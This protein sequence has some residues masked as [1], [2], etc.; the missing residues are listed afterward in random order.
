MTKAIATFALDV[1]GEWVVQTL[2]RTF[3]YDVQIQLSS[4]RGLSKRERGV[5]VC[6]SLRPDNCFVGRH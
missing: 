4:I 2:S 6:L 5:F 1:M 3:M